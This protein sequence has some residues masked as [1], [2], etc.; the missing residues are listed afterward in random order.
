MEVVYGALMISVCLGLYMAVAPGAGRSGWLGLALV[1]SI[2]VAGVSYSNHKEAQAEA[3]YQID[4]C[5]VSRLRALCER[6]W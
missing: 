1:I 6:G 5:A 3:R 2:L 4:E